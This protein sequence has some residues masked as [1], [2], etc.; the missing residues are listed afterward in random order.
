MFSL[1]YHWNALYTL[2]CN[3]KYRTWSWYGGISKHAT[4][5]SP[6]SFGPAGLPIHNNL[7]QFQRLL[8]G[9]RQSGSDSASAWIPPTW[10]ICRTTNQA[11]LART[12]T[13]KMK[14][15]HKA[16]LQQ[17]CDSPPAEILLWTSAPLRKK[18]AL[19][20]SVIVCLVCNICLNSLHLSH[21]NL[22]LKQK[23]A[24]MGTDKKK[25]G[26]VR[27]EQRRLGWLPRWTLYHIREDSLPEGLGD[28]NNLLAI[29]GSVLLK[30]CHIFFLLHVF[31]C[32]KCAY[33]TQSAVYTRFCQ[34]QLM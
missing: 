7:G 13:V 8:G 4:P 16:P 32:Q 12:S 27:G 3:K 26:E 31:I 29:K 23:C 9:G 18:G 15:T 5:L 20:H 25:E 33:A 6:L 1:N 17:P 21:L 2:R 30:N 14:G 19:R 28:G 11:A 34:Q 22:S 10:H 24:L